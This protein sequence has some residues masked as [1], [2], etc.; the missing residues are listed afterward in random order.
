MLDIHTDEVMVVEKVKDDPRFSGVDQL[1]ELDIRSYAGARITDE[2]G[3]AL[4]AVCCIH[5]ELRSY[6]GRQK[7]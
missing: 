2:E 1:D 3:N 4:G 7:P 5:G 6:T